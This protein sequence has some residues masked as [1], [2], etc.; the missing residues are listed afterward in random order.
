MF[1]FDYAQQVQYPS[2]PDQPGAIFFK[3]PRKCEL[4][5]I[6]NEAINRQTTYAIDEAVDRRKGANN[7]ISYLHHY[8]ENYGLGEKILFLQADNCCGQNKNN[9]MMQYLHWRVDQN[10]HTKI[11]INFMI[12]GHTKF[13]PNRC[14]GLIKQMV[15]SI[16]DVANIIN[17]SSAGTNI[18]QLFINYYRL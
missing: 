2:N 13:G 6:C 7:V 3:V 11:S 18:A 5:G 9:A 4:F 14:F 10:L 17:D 1:S 15:S 16:F 8:L 12:A